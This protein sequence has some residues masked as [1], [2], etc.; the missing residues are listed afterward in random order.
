MTDSLKTESQLRGIAKK[1]FIYEKQNQEQLRAKENLIAQTKLEKQKQ[2]NLIVIIALNNCWKLFLGKIITVCLEGTFA[3]S[4]HVKILSNNFI[5]VFS[6][7][8]KYVATVK[9]LFR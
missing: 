1:E 6:F 8:K 9:K 5:V 7:L 3:S 2:I 4:K